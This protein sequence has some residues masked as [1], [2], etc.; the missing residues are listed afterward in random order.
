MNVATIHQAKSWFQVLQTTKLSQTAVM[1]LEVGG[2]SSGE[3]NVHEKSDQVLYV[4]EGE[5]NAEV[6]GEKRTLHAGDICVVP[7]GTRHR[8]E[9]TGNKRALT[10][11]VY[12]PPEYAPDEQG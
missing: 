12:A 9:N 10:L 3:T 8:F 1:T 5:V 11:S 6:A 4:V 2:Q 7:A